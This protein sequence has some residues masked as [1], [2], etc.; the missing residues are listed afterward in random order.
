MTWDPVL[1]R[2]K[3]NKCGIILNEKDEVVQ[4]QVGYLLDNSQSFESYIEIPDK[5][6][7]RSCYT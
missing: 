6:Y 4:V 1:N 5:H 7:H 3:C 2:Y